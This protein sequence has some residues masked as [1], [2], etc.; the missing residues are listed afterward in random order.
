MYLP[1]ESGPVMA[2]P[3]FICVKS[4][5]YRLTSNVSPAANSTLVF[6]VELEKVFPYADPK[7]DLEN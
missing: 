1:P 4:A 7:I 5:K 3:A 6:D 2:V